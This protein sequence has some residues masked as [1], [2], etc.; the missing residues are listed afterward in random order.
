M[1]PWHYRVNGYKILG[2]F[3]FCLIVTEMQIKRQIRNVPKD[4]SIVVNF[5]VNIF[6]TYSRVAAA[7]KIVK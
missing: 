6:K 2:E 4:Y 5:L 1:S 3:V 7:Y